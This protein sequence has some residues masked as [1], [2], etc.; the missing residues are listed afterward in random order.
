[1]KES[2]QNQMDSSLSRQMGSHTVNVYW[3]QASDMVTS[4]LVTVGSRR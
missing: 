4:M 2:G 1:M 3:K